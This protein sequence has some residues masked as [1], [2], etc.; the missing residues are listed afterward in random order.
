MPGIRFLAAGASTGTVDGSILN[1]VLFI[2][3]AL[4]VSFLCSLWETVLLSTSVSY[5][6]LMAEHGRV[7]AAV[8]RYHRE[9]IE[10]ANSAI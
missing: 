6:E 5:V 8:M 1:L 7:A 4:I 2:L 10:Q 9:N 3:I